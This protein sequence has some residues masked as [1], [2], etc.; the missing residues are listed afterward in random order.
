MT[1]HEV[2][3]LMV[4]G[5]VVLAA[6]TTWFDVSPWRIS[7]LAGIATVVTVV[8]AAHVAGEACGASARMGTGDRLF[9][10][11]IVSSLTLYAAAALAAV[12]DG[13]RLGKA[14]DSE[15][16]ISRGV[17][18]PIVSALGVGVV[19]FAFLSAI[20]PCLG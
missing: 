10:I 13:I 12:V 17:G 7:G 1:L 18:I 8:L 11:M 6:A 3:W 19:F 20:G 16:A 2:E 14:G 5:A 9:E 15:A 4:I